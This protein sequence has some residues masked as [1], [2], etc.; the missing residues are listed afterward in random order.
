MEDLDLVWGP[1]MECLA[2]C[3]RH[4]LDLG[5][6]R[7]ML[8]AD[9]SQ[10]ESRTLAWLS[11]HTAKLQTF[12][13]G[14]D[15]YKVA[16]NL[17]WGI[18]YDK[19]KKDERQLGKIAELSLGFQGGP[20]ALI[21]MAK[22]Y[23]MDLDEEKAIEVVKAFRKGN[24]PIT[25]LWKQANDCA[26]E[27]IRNP[28]V[29]QE[30]NSKLRI[31]VSRKLGFPVMF[32]ELPSKRLLSY[33]LPE[34]RTIYKV[35]DQTTKRWN[36][37]PAYRALDADGDKR[38]GVW[39]VQE[40]SYYGKLDGKS[41]WGRCITHGGTLVQNATQATAGDFMWLG[42]VT[43]ERAGFKCLFPVHDEQLTEYHP[44]NGDSPEK[45]ARC[46]ETLPSWAQDFPTAA[47]GGIYDFY[48]KD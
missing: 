1:P 25:K 35:Q 27:A 8:G 34:I 24:E 3:V 39:V 7:Q 30:I 16:V 33:P 42:G 37:I 19:V 9:L 26:V 36:T 23:G 12:R 14:L 38:D 11:G 45:L 40:I 15:L 5:P 21:R 4:F 6:G 17:M 13:Q 2:S 41:I 44:E 43:A 32:L 29:W 28:G 22:N 47:V 10:I 20:G 48:T 18:D 31:G 46:M